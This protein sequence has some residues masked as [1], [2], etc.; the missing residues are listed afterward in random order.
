MI[1]YGCV[2]LWVYPT[3]LYGYL[4]QKISPRCDRYKL[5]VIALGLLGIYKGAMF[6]REL[7]RDAGHA[8]QYLLV[9]Q[10]YEIFETMSYDL[11]GYTFYYPKEGDRTGYIDFPASPVKAEDI[12]IGNTIEDGFHDVIHTK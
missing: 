4:Y 8:R 11:H 6:G 10:D 12:F 1:R 5:A 3:L 2:F 9:Q 7:I